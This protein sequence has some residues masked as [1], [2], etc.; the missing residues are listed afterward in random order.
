MYKIEKTN[1]GIKMALSGYINLEE[2]REWQQEILK[3]IEEQPAKIGLLIDM[4][5]LKPMPPECQQIVIEAQKKTMNQIIR[6]ATITNQPIT[7]IQL[8]RLGKI[9]GV[10]KTKMYVNASET[11]YWE[12]IAVYWIIKGKQID[13]NSQS[14][15]IKNGHLEV[16]M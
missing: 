8:K 12:E 16:I 1:Y 7:D 11:K 9:S 5:E 15:K 4:R 10:N 6:S 14:V 3:A 2:I 13:P